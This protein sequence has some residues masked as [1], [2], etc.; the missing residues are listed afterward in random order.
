MEALPWREVFSFFLFCF[1]FLFCESN[2]LG[3]VASTCVCVFFKVS[4]RDLSLV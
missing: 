4:S 1:L 2:A 3:V